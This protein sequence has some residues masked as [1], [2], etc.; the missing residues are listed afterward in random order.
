MKN[1]VKLLSVLTIVVAMAAFATSCKE[2]VMVISIALDKVTADVQVGATLDLN[3]IVTPADA[4]N[5]EIKWSTSNAA[6]A[7]VTDGTVTGVALGTATITAKAKSDTTKTATCSV[8]IIPSNGQTITVTGE[9]TTNT[10]WYS[11]AKYLLNGFVYVANNATLTIQP[12][13]IIKGVYGSKGA[14]IVERG[15]KIIA[16]GTAITANRIYIRQACRS[17][18]CRRLGWFGYLRKSYNKQT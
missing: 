11:N 14:L 9:I 16:A 15:S 5:Q 8:T 6:V 18:S 3:V 7:T 12:G 2:D 1:F 10:T 4:T 13:T 17:E